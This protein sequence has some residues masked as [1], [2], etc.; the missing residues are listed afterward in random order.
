MVLH[1][2][3][4]PEVAS[5]HP[6]QYREMFLLHLRLLM[7]STVRWVHW[8]YTTGRW[9]KRRRRGLRLS[10]LVTRTSSFI[11]YTRNMQSLN[12]FCHI[13]AYSCWFQGHSLLFILLLE[14][15][16]YAGLCLGPRPQLCSWNFGLLGWKTWKHLT[17]VRLESLNYCAPGKCL[18][19]LYPKMALSVYA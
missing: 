12:G 8:L 7:T 4:H 5:L 9:S 19:R 3:F 17:W 1:S 15:S 14:G 6:S 16:L 18:L 13:V 2:S 11:G 10:G